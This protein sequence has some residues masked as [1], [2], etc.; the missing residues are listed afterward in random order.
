MDW[1]QRTSLRVQHLHP[2][3]THGRGSLAARPAF[4]PSRDLH[5]FFLQNASSQRPQLM[6]MHCYQQEKKASASDLASQQMQGCLHSRLSQTASFH[7]QRN[8]QHLNQRTETAVDM[9]PQ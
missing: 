2:V 9:S 1:P 3:A 8:D 6:T 7:E 4:Q 5:L